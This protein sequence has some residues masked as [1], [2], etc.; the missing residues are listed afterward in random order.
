MAFTVTIHCRNSTTFGE[1][2]TKCLG[3]T[4]E[5]SEIYRINNNILYEWLNK[6]GPSL[7]F[8]IQ[9]NILASLELTLACAFMM[10]LS[11]ETEA[12][13]KRCSENFMFW[14]FRKSAP[15]I[16]VE[17]SFSTVA[18]FTRSKLHQ[19][20]FPKNIPKLLEHLNKHNW[21]T[22]SEVSEH[23][24]ACCRVKHNFL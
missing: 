4:I 2:R 23:R 12:V 3:F 1:I 11:Q 22:A 9:S 24:L 18:N 10:A 21:T 5:I 14:I 8:T 7:Q 17:F 20:H 16:V 6:R 19:V 13:A 15:K